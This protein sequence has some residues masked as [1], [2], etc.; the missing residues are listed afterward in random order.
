VN[1]GKPECSSVIIIIII[2]IIII[3]L[4]THPRIGENF[5]A[6]AEK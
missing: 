3:L 5:P 6:E 1:W 4:M 2:I